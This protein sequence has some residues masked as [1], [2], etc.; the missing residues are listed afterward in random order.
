[1][2]LPQGTIRFASVFLFLVLAMNF[3]SAQKP[4]TRP[5]GDSVPDGKHGQSGQFA[6]P[7]QGP[8]G[9]A[10]VTGNGISYHGGPVLKGNPVPIYLIFYGNWNGSGSNTAASVS[11]IEHFVSTLGNTPIEHVATTYGDT[12]GNVSGNVSLGG[13]ATVSSST[14]LTDSS[15]QTTVAN[16]LNSG[17]LPRNGNGIYMVLT[18]SNINETSGFCTQYCGFHTH[19]T[20][21][22]VDIKY[23]FVG[24]PDRCP[25]GCEIQSTGPNSPASGIGGADGL[26]NVLSHEQFEAITDPD[27]N[28]WFDSSGQEDSDKCNFNFGATST[29]NA[30]GLCSAGS[31]AAKYN[32]T[33]GS[34][35]WMIQQQWENA[36]GGKCVQH[37]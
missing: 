34:H 37:L 1:M 32:Q 16:V 12:T 21:G 28:A 27:L 22:G 24:N 15:L 14:N 2:K 17:A 11:L 3:M 35:N 29:C 10:V 31:G 13:V 7:V 36:N 33:F 19:A 18:S 25:S 23:G 30:N 8:T 26:I 5:D 4:L 9:Q 20:L 6:Q